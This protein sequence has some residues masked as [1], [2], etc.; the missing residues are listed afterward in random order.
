[1]HTST[2]E[3]PSGGRACAKLR[4]FVSA[5]SRKDAKCDGALVTRPTARLLPWRT[6]ACDDKGLKF[7]PERFRE[8][9]TNNRLRMWST[10]F[11]A[12]YQ[13]CPLKFVLRPSTGSRSRRAL[14]APAARTRARCRVPLVAAPSIEQFLPTVLRPIAE[15]GWTAGHLRK[16]SR[17]CRRLGSPLYALLLERV[18]ADLGSKRLVSG[19][20]SGRTSTRRSRHRLPVASHELGTPFGDAR[21]CFAARI[22]ISHNGSFAK[23]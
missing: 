16:Q 2:V 20:A 5:A 12:A 21:G 15:R 19:F 6:C 8:S 7:R 9:H 11:V 14:P 23:W 10:A 13:P 18:A 3:L 4:E 22:S 1:M 17:C